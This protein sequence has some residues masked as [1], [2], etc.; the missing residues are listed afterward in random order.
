MPIDYDNNLKTLRADLRVY[1]EEH[2][3]QA[4]FHSYIYSGIMYTSIVTSL[5]IGF[6]LS[7][8]TQQGSISIKYITGILSFVNS[9]L[10]SIIKFKNFEEISLAHRKATK[11][12]LGLYKSIMNGKE[13]ET[14]EL[15]RETNEV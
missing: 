11:E 14:N 2:S 5:A 12:Y 8:T 4:Q 1:I 3:R 13:N 9:I 7:I 10:I 6:V 15:I